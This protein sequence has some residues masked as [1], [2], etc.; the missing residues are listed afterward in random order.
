MQPYCEVP[1]HLSQTDCMWRVFPIV[2]GLGVTLVG[3]GVTIETRLANI[4][5][6]QLERTVKIA[7]MDKTVSDLIKDVANP[8]PKPETKIQ[9]EQMSSDHDKMETRLDRVEERMNNLHDFMMQVAPGI[10]KQTPAKR[11]SYGPFKLDDQG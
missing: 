1:N 6:I 2:A 5:T 4:N 9:L 8:A 3:W 11:G 10:I 7:A